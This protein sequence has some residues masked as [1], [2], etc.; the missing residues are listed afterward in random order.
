MNNKFIQVEI[1]EYSVGLNKYIHSEFTFLNTDFIKSITEFS[2]S[3]KRET[4]KIIDS[5]SNYDLE[6][7]YI[8]EFKT[9]ILFCRLLSEKF[10][11]N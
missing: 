4:K 6:E 5:L 10:V 11:L 9:D 8:I 2:R 3:K 1:L 7:I